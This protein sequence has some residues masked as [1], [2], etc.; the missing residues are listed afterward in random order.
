M[1][2]VVSI[3]P[4]RA[5]AVSFFGTLLIIASHK[6]PNLREFCTIITPFRN[7]KSSGRHRLAIDELREQTTPEVASLSRMW[8]PVFMSLVSL[9]C[10]SVAFAFLG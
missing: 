3:R 8:V 6:R 5:T 1:E 10:L 4:L 7:I 2:K 9:V